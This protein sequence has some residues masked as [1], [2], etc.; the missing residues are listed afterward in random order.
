MSNACEILQDG[1]STF[2]VLLNC[3]VNW[4]SILFVYTRH[5]YIHAYLIYTKMDIKNEM[6][7]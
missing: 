6:Q 5:Y 1:V 3:G 2:D 4:T 7:F